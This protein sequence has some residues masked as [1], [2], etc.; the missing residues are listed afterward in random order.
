[1][2][3]RI[4]K[5]GTKCRCGANNEFVATVLQVRIGHRGAVSYMVR[6]WVDDKAEVD[7]F[8]PFELVD[9]YEA[10]A[11]PELIEVLI[12]SAEAAAR[13]SNCQFVITP[14][15]NEDDPEPE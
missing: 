8:E 3:L 15:P 4:R 6:Y 5:P 12:K 7:E 2:R 10:D 14:V 13:K 9:D 1:M 11:D